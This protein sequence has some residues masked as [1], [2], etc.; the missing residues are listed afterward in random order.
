MAIEYAER[1]ALDH[2]AIGDEFF[3]RLAA[4]FSPEEILELTVTIGF[5]IGIGRSFTVL[6]LAGISTSTG[7]ANRHPVSNQLRCLY[8][9]GAEH[10]RRPIRHWLLGELLESP[11][12]CGSRPVGC[13]DGLW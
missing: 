5:C 12:E 10:P 2:R 7:V 11:V 13:R 1:F 4:K 8:P 6:D 3:E 9:S